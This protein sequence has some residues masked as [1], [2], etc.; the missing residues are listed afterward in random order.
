MS[1]RDSNYSLYILCLKG[2]SILPWLT[3]I[4]WVVLVMSEF[5]TVCCI[6]SALFNRHYHSHWPAPDEATCV[7]FCQCHL[8]T[9]SST[10][11]AIM[12]FNKMLICLLAYHFNDI[13]F[14]CCEHRYALVFFSFSAVMLCYVCLGCAIWLQLFYGGMHDDFFHCLVACRMSLFPPWY[15]M[16]ITVCIIEKCETSI[17]RK[18]GLL[19]SK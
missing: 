2:I 14:L 11:Q 17:D 1:K 9:T 15:R 10:I 12:I 19:S 7:H 13:T 18:I 3:G 8:L 6:S 16:K 5:G 4:F